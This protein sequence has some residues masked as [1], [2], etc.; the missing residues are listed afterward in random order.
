[1]PDE[2]ATN[3]SIATSRGIVFMAQHPG[4]LDR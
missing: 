1:M 2:Q 4:V 3:A